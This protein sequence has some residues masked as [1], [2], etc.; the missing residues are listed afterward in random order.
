MWSSSL[1]DSEPRESLVIHL[2]FPARISSLNEMMDLTTKPLVFDVENG[3]QIEHLS[4]VV[5]SLKDQVYQQ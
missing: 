5:R 4:F 1:T 2:S 3:G